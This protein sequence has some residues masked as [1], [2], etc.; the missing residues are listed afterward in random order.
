V[1]FYC[2]ITS[3]GCFLKSFPDKWLIITSHICTGIGVSLLYSVFESWSV[4]ELSHGTLRSGDDKLPTFFFIMNMSNSFIAIVAGVV[5]NELADAFSPYAPFVGSTVL[6]I[7]AAA[8]CSSLWNENKAGE[9]NVSLSSD[10]KD[11]VFEEDDGD[12]KGSILSDL[13]QTILSS[14]TRN[15]IAVGLMQTAFETS[16][17]TFIF[18]WNPILQEVCDDIPYGLTYAAFMVAMMTGNSLFSITSHFIGSA[19]FLSLLRVAFVIGLLGCGIAMHF[20]SF[21]AR[22]FGF[23]LFEMGVGCFWPCI[24]FLRGKHFPEDSRTTFINL[25]RIPTNFIVVVILN[26]CSPPHPSRNWNPVIL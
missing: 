24:G 16:L 2:L 17:F 26:V 6:C 7:I 1:L 22:I 8:I 15:V 4:H 14:L 3:I 20:S 18:F 10:L 5:A 21:S 9:G 25:F 12:K 23:L 11:D 19:G 13:F